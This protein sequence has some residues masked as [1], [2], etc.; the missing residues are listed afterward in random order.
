MQSLVNML[1]VSRVTQF[2]NHSWHIFLH[3]LPCWF[4]K[5]QNQA[6]YASLGIQL[7]DIIKYRGYLFSVAAVEKDHYPKIYVM[8]AC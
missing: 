1:N 5:S 8:N 4:D 2:L 6:Q 7:A 3:I